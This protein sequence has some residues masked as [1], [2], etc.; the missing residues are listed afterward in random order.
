MSEEAA[1]DG[2]ADLLSVDVAIELHAARNL[3]RRAIQL[4]SG[5]RQSAVYDCIYLALAEA[6]DGEL[7]TAD[8]R[9]YRAASPQFSSVRWLGEANVPN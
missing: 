3:Y 5:L 1:E 8:E 2:I 7:W 9:F 4:A 6:Q